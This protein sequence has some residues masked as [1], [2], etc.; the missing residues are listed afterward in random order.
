[1][2][3]SLAGVLIGSVDIG[4]IYVLNAIAGVVVAA[5]VMMRYRGRAA[6]GNTGIGWKPLVEGL[7][8]TYRSRI[9][10][11]T[12][13]LDFIATFS[14]RHAPCCRSWPATSCT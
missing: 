7:R 3:P 5:L 8:F 10:W 14:R 13:L 11:S 6:A 12:M 9:I 2:G 4:W 1:M